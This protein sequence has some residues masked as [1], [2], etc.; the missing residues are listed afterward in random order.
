[1]LTR[2]RI[3]ALFAELNDELCT[4]GV[5]GDVF[6]VRGAAMAVAY[7]ARPATRDVD[8][9]WHPATD[10]R[11]AAQR[12]AAH[13]DDLATDWLNDGVKGFLPGAAAGSRR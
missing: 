6:V 3:L 5:R 11:A 4:A 13:H 1:M 8:A 10:V 7:D 12:I 2:D 9:I